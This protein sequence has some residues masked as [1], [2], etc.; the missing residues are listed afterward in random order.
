MRYALRWVI[1]GPEIRG[2]VM[3]ADRHFSLPFAPEG[4]APPTRQLE[5][6]F[7][8]IF[9]Q[10]KVASNQDYDLRLAVIAPC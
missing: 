3:P 5:G 6:E 7:Y 1:V 2:Q 10:L 4:S 8:S 9:G